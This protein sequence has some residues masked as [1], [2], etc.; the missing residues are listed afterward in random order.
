[1]KIQPL[2]IEAV[3]RNGD[4]EELKSLHVEYCMECGCCSF[5]CPAKRNLTQTMR[6]A[7]AELKN[8]R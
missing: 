2:D 1:M 6:M 8:K 4:V 5:V 7:K 3:L